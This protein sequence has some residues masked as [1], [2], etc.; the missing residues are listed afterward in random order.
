MIF[1]FSSC[2]STLP[3][4]PVR[5][6]YHVFFA[7]VRSAVCQRCSICNIKTYQSVIGD[8]VSSPVPDM[9]ASYLRCQTFLASSGRETDVA[10]MMTARPQG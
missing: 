8:D 2:R 3:S 7:V 10:V 5:F 4:L 9:S 1:S 6:S